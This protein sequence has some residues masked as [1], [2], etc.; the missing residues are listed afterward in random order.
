VL[1]CLYNLHAGQHISNT[2][3]FIVPSDMFQ[4]SILLPC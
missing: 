2:L 1:L 4:N 3:E